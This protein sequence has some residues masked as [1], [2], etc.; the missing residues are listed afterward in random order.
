MEAIAAGVQGGRDLGHSAA[1]TH[2]LAHAL[3]ATVE[4]SDA[5]QLSAQLQQST[6]RGEAQL[7]ALNNARAG[8][9]SAKEKCGMLLQDCI[10]G[11]EEG[12]PEQGREGL[13]RELLAAE[14]HIRASR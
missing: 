9:S 1:D 11:I 12:A 13:L 4:A 14:E 8:F 10:E 3:A 7:E 2:S 6:Q 5:G